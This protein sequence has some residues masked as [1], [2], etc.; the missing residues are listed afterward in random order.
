[1]KAMIQMT[2]TSRGCGHC[3]TA[4]EL[5]SGGQAEDNVNS[6]TRVSSVAGRAA[7]KQGRVMSGSRPYTQKAASNVV[8]AAFVGRDGIERIR[9]PQNRFVESS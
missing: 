1:M 7:V 6:P 5:D 4:N 8:G 9:I 3:L 2:S